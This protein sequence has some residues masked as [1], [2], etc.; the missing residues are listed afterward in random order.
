MNK[1]EIEQW[2]ASLQKIDTPQWMLDIFSIS[3]HQNNTEGFLR[4]VFKATPSRHWSDVLLARCSL[5]AN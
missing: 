5:S 1:K 4:D 3:V 2:L